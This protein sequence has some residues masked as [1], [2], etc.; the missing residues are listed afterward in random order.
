[1]DECQRPV[2]D[3]LLDIENPDTGEEFS[4][5][6]H[7]NAAGVIYAGHLPLGDESYPVRCD[8]CEMGARVYVF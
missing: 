3:E 6:I 8:I 2:F 7:R 4:V 1:M 5:V